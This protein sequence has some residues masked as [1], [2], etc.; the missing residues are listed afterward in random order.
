MTFTPTLSPAWN[1][2]LRRWHCLIQRTVLQWANE[3]EVES[4]DSPVVR[5]SFSAGVTQALESDCVDQLMLRADQA[6]YAAKR[7]GRDQDAALEIG[8][9]DHSPAGN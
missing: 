4:G 5:Y 6:L 1:A 2:A 3:R 8:S 9:V 7:A